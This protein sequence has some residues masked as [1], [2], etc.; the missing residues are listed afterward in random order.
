MSEGWNTIESDAGVFTYLLDNLGVKDVQFEE[1]LAV[2]VESLRQ[3]CPIYGLIFLF[4]YPTNENTQ[5]D[6]MP[7]DGQYDHKATNNL[8]FAKQ[9][10]QNACGTQAL[11]SVLLNKDREIDIGAPLRDFKQFT[12]TFPAEL[13]GEALSNSELIRKVH[14]SFAK[15]SPFVDETQSSF[16]ENDDVYHF[17]AYTSVN[18]V[19]YELDGL[20]DAPISH[21]P[22]TSQEFPEKIVP[23]IQ[24]RISR[25][26][27]NE[28]RFN[29]LA[30]VKDLRIKAHSIG[31]QEMLE[32]E[33]QKRTRWAFENALRGHNFLGFTGELMKQVTAA[34]LKEGPG[35]YEKWLENA[36]KNS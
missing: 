15:S 9:T 8:F 30:M 26:P 12:A 23:V 13:R 25:Y 29:L 34:K 24:R 22:S 7:K 35:A 21:G 10:I 17:I 16:A 18:D 3:L 28:I 4:K 27:L 31:D 5:S 11:L 20:H 33:K 19:L 1:L 14:N 32:R 2:D 6:G 36:K